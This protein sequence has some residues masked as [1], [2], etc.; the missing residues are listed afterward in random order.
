[1]RGAQPEESSSTKRTAAT[2]ADCAGGSSHA[3]RGGCGWA[4]GQRPILNESRHATDPVV[5]DTGD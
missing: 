5:T 4:S 3:A 2:L 1:M